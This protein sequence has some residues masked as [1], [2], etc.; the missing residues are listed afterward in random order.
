LAG[1]RTTNQQLG[2]PKIGEFRNSPL[3]IGFAPSGSFAIAT[4]TSATRRPI[5]E[6]M[7]GVMTAIAERLVLVFFVEREIG[8]L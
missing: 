4:P 8:G 1:G 7:S 3:A 2:S 6:A 5:S